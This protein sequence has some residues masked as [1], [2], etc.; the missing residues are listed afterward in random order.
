MIDDLLR[1]AD[2]EKSS[3]LKGIIEFLVNPLLRLIGEVDQNV[4]AYD[5]VTA[6]DIRIL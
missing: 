5:K 3:R 2:E 4:S 1:T 6:R